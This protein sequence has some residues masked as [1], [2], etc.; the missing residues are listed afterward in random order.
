MKLLLAL[1]LSV[2][3][4]AFA[5]EAL[6]GERAYWAGGIDE[7]LYGTWVRKSDSP[8]QKLIHKP[9]GT[10]ESFKSAS[11]ERPSWLGRYLITRKWIDSEGNI[12]YKWHWVEIGGE[13]AT[14]LAKLVIL[15]TP[16]NLCMLPINTQWKSIQ[17]VES[18]GSLPVSSM[19]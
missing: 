18:I 13:K 10:F 12:R 6:A 3:L 8:P 9:D 11:S 1:I 14:R 17:K 7:V 2:T 4:V 5:A 19:P 15:E 16:S